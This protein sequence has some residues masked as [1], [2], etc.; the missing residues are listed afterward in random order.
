M[1]SVATCLFSSAKICFYTILKL[2]YVAQP[3]P[4]SL[5][6]NLLLVVLSFENSAFEFPEILCWSF[7]ICVGLIYFWS[8]E[9]VT[10]G[11]DWVSYFP[12]VVW[13]LFLVLL[14]VQG[15]FEP[16]S[17]PPL[18]SC[19]TSEGCEMAPGVRPPSLGL[20]Q[21]TCLLPAWIITCRRWL[22]PHVEVSP[23]EESGSRK[24]AVWSRLLEQV[25]CPGGPFHAWNFT[26]KLS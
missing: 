2:P 16:W 12:N 19:I 26:F 14:P 15:P 17:P 23:S 1:H 21:G 10:F 6:L 4:L 11:C 20:H 7:L 18:H 24:K 22:G 8:L 25:C 9:V 5:V 13:I 3:S